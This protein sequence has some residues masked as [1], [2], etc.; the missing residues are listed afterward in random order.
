MFGMSMEEEATSPGGQRELDEAEES[1]N[2]SDSSDG[3]DFRENECPACEQ[4]FG[5]QD[6]DRLWAFV[7]SHVAHSTLHAAK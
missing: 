5:S 6:K 4:T 3:E 7:D 2:G 1:A